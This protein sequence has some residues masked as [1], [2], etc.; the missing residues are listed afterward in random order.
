KKNKAVLTKLVADLKQ[1]HSKLDEIPTLIIDDEADQTSVNTT[2]PTR[3]DDEGRKERTA[4]NKLI[5]QLVTDLRRSQYVGYT[6]TPFANVFISPDDSEDIFPKD[7]IL[8]LAPSPAYMGGERFHDLD[9]VPVG[10]EDDPELSNRRAYVRDLD[11]ADSAEARGELRQAI[12]AFVLSG[13]IKLWRQARGEGSFKHHTM[14]VHE[15]V[16]IVEHNE[17]AETIVD[18]WNTAGYSSAEGKA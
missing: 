17:L 8:S 16:R 18:V 5:S 7:F 4:I 15:S 10:A 3:L 11:S 12:D 6:A 9:G 1:I 14:L 2:S 13:A